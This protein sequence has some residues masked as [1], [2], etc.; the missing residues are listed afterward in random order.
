VETT[1]QAEKFYIKH[2]SL[3]LDLGILLKTIFDTLTFGGRA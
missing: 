2:Q 3:W 1:G